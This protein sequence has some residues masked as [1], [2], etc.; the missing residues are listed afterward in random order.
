MVDTAQT[1]A[2]AAAAK[3]QADITAKQQADHKA[4]VEAVKKEGEELK[5]TQAEQH[6]KLA[7]AKPTPTQDENDRAKLGEVI[8]EHEDDGSGPDPHTE[9]NQKA[10][11]RAK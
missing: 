11:R 2:D 8:K 1:Q 6:A 10:Q 7:A 9:Q 3:Q 4:H 5:K